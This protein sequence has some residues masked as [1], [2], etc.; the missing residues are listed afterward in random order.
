MDII[1][2]SCGEPWA[3][4]YVLHDDPEAFRRKGGKIMHC[5]CCEENK[6]LN[7][8]PNPI[9]RAKLDLAAEMAD[10]LGDDID[11]LACELEDFGL[12]S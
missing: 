5:P 10:L 1:C 6:K 11:G 2:I 3:I 12:T 7:G 9:Q 8:P 4:D